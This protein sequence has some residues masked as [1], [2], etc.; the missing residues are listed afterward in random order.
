MHKSPSP[1]MLQCDP[2]VAWEDP[3]TY[4]WHEAYLLTIVALTNFDRKT[5]SCCGVV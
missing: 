2:A 3:M 1:I 5:P 4:A